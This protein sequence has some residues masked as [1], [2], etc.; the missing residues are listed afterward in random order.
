M[1]VDE[2]EDFVLS[3]GMIN[4]ELAARE[5]PLIFNLSMH[6]RVD[7]LNSS[8]HLEADLVEFMEMICRCCDQASFAPPTELGPDGMPLQ[9]PLSV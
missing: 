2:F 6:I 4:S 7:E 1:M 5:I 3:S 8:R 9:S